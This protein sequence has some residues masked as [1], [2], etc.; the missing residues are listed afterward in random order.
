MPQK[1]LEIRSHTDALTQIRSQRRL[2]PHPC[3]LASPRTSVS[4]RA[5]VLLG[6]FLAVAHLPGRWHWSVLGSLSSF[7]VNFSSLASSAEEDFVNFLII[8]S[9]ECAFAKNCGVQSTFSTELLP[10]QDRSHRTHALTS[11]GRCYASP[12]PV[13]LAC[14]LLMIP[15]GGLEL[16]HLLLRHVI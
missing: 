8:K 16:G 12:L 5:F 1:K 6:I 13:E 4:C 15:G 10:I 11:G 3:V 7:F 9:D 14:C 2:N